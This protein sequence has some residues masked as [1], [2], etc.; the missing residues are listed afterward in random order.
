[1]SAPSGGSGGS[2]D[3]RPTFGVA[4]LAEETR[5]RFVREVTARVPLSRLVELHLFAPMRQGGMESGVAVLAATP[6]LPPAA[7]AEVPAEASVEAP[8]EARAEAPLEIAEPIAEET[9]ALAG[10]PVP[11]GD[12]TEEAAG[13]PPDAVVEAEAEAEIDV[14]AAEPAPESE[15]DAGPVAQPAS[16]EEILEAVPEQSAPPVAAAATR[17]R[18]TV[19]TARY[20]LV[21]KGPD[22]GKWD[23]EVREEADAPLITVEAVVRGVQQRSGDASEPERLD[24]ASVARMLG[25]PLPER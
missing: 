8:D 10:D 4:R 2:G 19:F 7:A 14:D 25:V 18:H 21:L 11:D 6:D 20:R 17:R 23:V 5:E 12:P 16:V 9:E 22:R 3:Q 1:M 13:P 15:P 24:A